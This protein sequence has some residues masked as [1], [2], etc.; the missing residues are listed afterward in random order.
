VGRAQRRKGAA[1]EREVAEVFARH[2]FDLAKRSGDAGQRDGDLDHVGIFY[3]EV[4]RRETL[5][6]P[7]WLREVASKCPPDMV[8]LLVFRRSRMAWQACLPLGQFLA[9]LGDV[10]LRALVRSRAALDLPS[11]LREAAIDRSSGELPA[12]V[13]RGASVPW[14][15]CL[16]LEDLLAASVTGA[17]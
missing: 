1:A 5:A 14:H 10:H 4:R 7:A 15:A 17:A 2:G 11:W 12:V 9:L 3:V 6:V 16:S 8:G 13:F